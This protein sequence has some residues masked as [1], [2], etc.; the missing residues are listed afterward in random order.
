MTLQ[1]FGE[2]EM[3]HTIPVASFKF[4]KLDDLKLCFNYKNVKPMWQS[5]NRHK[6]CKLLNSVV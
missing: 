3:D 2:W 1:N 4:E 5:D 6:S